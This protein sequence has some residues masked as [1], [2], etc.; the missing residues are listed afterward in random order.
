MVFVPPLRG[1]REGEVPAKRAEGVS[2]RSNANAST[3][4]YPKCNSINFF[5]H[6]AH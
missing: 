1:F 2:T 6:S 5:P 4:S 3:A